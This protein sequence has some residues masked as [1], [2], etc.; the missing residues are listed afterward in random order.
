MIRLDL[1]KVTPASGSHVGNETEI[2]L[3]RYQL[4]GTVRAV[5]A[6]CMLATLISQAHSKGNEAVR[7]LQW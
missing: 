1:A 5:W 4:I 6:L 7:Q 3:V 2:L